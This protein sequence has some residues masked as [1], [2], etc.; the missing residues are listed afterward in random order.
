MNV[1]EL[2]N[3]RQIKY[4]EQ[5]NDYL[6]AC[7]N[8][9]H[10]DTNPSMR[11]DKITG[12]FH[13]FSCGFKGNLFR[14][15]GAEPNKT[16]IKIMELHKKIQK[17]ISNSSLEIPE[18]A[19]LFDREYRGISA[20]VYNEF[21]AFT[22]SSSKD[23]EDRLIFPISNISGDIKVFCGR[24]FQDAKPK[25][26]F[27][28]RHVSPPLFPY[29]AKPINGQIIIVEGI[30][31]VLNLYAKGLSNVVTAFGTDTLAKSAKDKLSHF[32]IL[33]TNKFWIMFD[34][35]KAG[36][37]AAKRLQHT[38]IKLGMNV[39]IIDLPDDMDPGDM[40]EADVNIIKTLLTGE[41]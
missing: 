36:R 25:Y 35:D 39:D 19:L 10:D 24:L 17:L 32:E 22:S 27:H 13:C 38:M 15:F 21:G 34:G 4:S 37:D 8:P 23:L 30:F 12:L 29:T 14:E 18:D 7:I 2:L 40:N 28:P 16:E 11:I 3:Q 41:V 9:E 5:G 33:G 1:T 26:K 20:D 31:D 6:V